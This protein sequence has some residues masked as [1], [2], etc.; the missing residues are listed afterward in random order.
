MEY[1]FGREMQKFK[2]D[3]KYWDI[4]KENI[5]FC[6]GLQ[7]GYSPGIDHDNYY[8]FIKYNFITDSLAFCNSLLTEAYVENIDIY[9]AV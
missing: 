5:I 7:V 3:L 9:Y 8:I 2:L 4:F 1:D 6:Y